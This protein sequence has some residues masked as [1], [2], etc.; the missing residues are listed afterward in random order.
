MIVKKLCRK[1]VEYNNFLAHFMCNYSTYILTMR[2]WVITKPQL[3]SF[4]PHD[5]ITKALKS[6]F[7]KFPKDL[8]V[9]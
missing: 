3:K 5:C 6:K 4:I 7:G 8:N 1:I 9:P 2:T